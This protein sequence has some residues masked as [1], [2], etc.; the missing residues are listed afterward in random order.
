MK[1]LIKPILK[2]ALKCLGLTYNHNPGFHH[3]LPTRKPSNPLLLEKKG[4]LALEKM[5][6]EYEFDTVLDVGSGDFG[7]AN[8][9]AMSSKRVTAIDIGSSIYYKR[10]NKIDKNVNF[11][12]GNYIDHVFEHQFDALW[13]CHV[14]EHQLN[15]NCFLKKIY[16]DIKHDGIVV[17]TVPPL[18]YRMS[19]GH[20]SL[21]TPGLLIYHLVLAGFDCRSAK[22]LTYGY[23][24]SIILR[25]KPAVLPKDLSLDHG[26]IHKLSRFMPPEFVEQGSAN[27][28]EINW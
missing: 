7:H 19:G 2:K 18:H 20:V 10:K 3:L 14:L 26:D 11:V 21:W 16:D 17:I 4:G 1:K 23:N 9:L 28:T 12:Q 8:V 25:K 5:L 6:A 15:I 13:V 24:I 27:F 22:L